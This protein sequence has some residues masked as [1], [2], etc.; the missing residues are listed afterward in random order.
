[1]NSLSLMSVKR[2]LEGFLRPIRK[3]HITIVVVTALGVMIWVVFTVNSILSQPS[4]ETYQ[5]EAQ[6]KAV[7]ANFDQS[8]IDTINKLRER[9][10]NDPATLPGGRIN[11]FSE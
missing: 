7:K 10:E 2:I 5:Q 3:Y 8:T 1:M 6:Q 4:D 11:P 9:Q